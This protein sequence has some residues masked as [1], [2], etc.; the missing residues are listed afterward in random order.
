MN[1]KFIK[2][3]FYDII[4]NHTNCMIIKLHDYKPDPNAMYTL[5]RPCDGILIYPYGNPVMLLE[6]KYAKTINTKYKLQPSQTIAIKECK[7]KR[8]PYTIVIGAY[9]NNN[10]KYKLVLADINMEYVIEKGN[11]ENILKFIEYYRNVIYKSF[12]EIKKLVM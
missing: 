7:E 1:E 9:N 4:K 5:A 3:K 11:K 10:L 12:Y 6:F 8:I 2:N